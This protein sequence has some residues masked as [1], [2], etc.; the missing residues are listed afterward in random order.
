M[1]CDVGRTSK[2]D[3]LSVNQ[4]IFA[5]NAISARAQYFMVTCALIP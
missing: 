4:E 2:A 5:R 1:K 3:Q